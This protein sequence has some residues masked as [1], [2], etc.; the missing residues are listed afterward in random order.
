M[1]RTATLADLRT[2]VQ[3]RGSYENSADITDAILLDFINEA[4][5]E[6]YDLL[7]QRWADY[8]VTRVTLATVAGADQIVLPTDFY[9][10]RKLE[11]VDSSAPSGYRALRPIDLAESHALG[12]TVVA[13]R[14]RYRLEAGNLVLMPTPNAVE[15]LRMFYIPYVQPF[16]DD[17][18]TFDGINGYEE[19]VIQFALL[20]CKMR[21]EL[22][23]ADIE[24]EIARL[25]MRVR[26]AGDGRDATE[27]LMYN[28][29]GPSDDGTEEEW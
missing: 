9:K 12:S 23:T 2:S 4:V 26:S 28:P 17:A 29:F 3:R 16:T 11:I 27:P 6:T 10:L 14:Y 21:E 25:T 13:K 20:R 5:A 18:D 22:P 24:R 1:A 8:Y 19:L 7:V 15:S